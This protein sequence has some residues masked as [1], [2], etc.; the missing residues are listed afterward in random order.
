[1]IEHVANSFGLQ[2]GCRVQKAEDIMTSKQRAF[3][4]SLASKE[5]TILQ[6]GKEGITPKNTASIEEALTARELVKIGIGK[7]CLDDL[8]QIA[9]TAAERTRSELVQVIGRKFV[10][11]REGSEEKKKIIL[12]SDRPDRSL[13]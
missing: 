1:M 6:I 9:E 7:N 2:A 3:L 12:P 11:Y 10:L 13:R 5:D 4:K 8:H